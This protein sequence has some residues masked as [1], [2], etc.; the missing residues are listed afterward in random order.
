MTTYDLYLESGPRRKKTMV[1]VPRLLG[2]IAVGPTTDEA[3]TATPVAIR[4]F[5]A[6]LH[7][8]GA[9]AGPDSPIEVRV[10]EHITEGYWV[11]NGDPAIVFAADLE[12]VTPAELEALIAR[13]EWL[14]L[15]ITALVAPLDPAEWDAEPASG[16]PIRRILQHVLEAE[17]SYVYWTGRPAGLPASGNILSKQQGEFLEWWAYVR[18]HEIAHLRRLAPEMLAEPFAQGKSTHTA[19]KLLRRM[20]EHQWEHLLEIQNRLLV[21]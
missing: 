21:P 14:R 10:A 11:G 6:F 17:Y 18:E 15:D 20:L 2:C 8:H 3:L 19:R 1:H 13:L 9:P 4:R 12:P 7:E 5:L 16:R